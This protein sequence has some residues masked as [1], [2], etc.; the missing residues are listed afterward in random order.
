MH[1]KMF[2]ASFAKGPNWIMLT[3]VLHA[4][5]DCMRNGIIHYIVQTV[6]Q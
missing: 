1:E 6:N 3:S 5:I 2:G 4:A